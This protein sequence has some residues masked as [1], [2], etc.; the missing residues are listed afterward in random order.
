M[1]CNLIWAN[2]GTMMVSE[3]TTDL[4]YTYHGTAWP[5]Y[6]DINICPE[7]VSWT[8]LVIWARI[9]YGSCILSP[10]WIC[11]PCRVCHPLWAIGLASTATQSHPEILCAGSES[12]NATLL[13]SFHLRKQESLKTPEIEVITVNCID[14]KS[15]LNSS[16]T[17]M[18]KQTTKRQ[19]FEMNVCSAK[20]AKLMKY[21]E[22]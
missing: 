18:R 22:I 3:S 12:A 11:L 19:L 16:Y 2:H 9:Y 15:V 8:H 14:R 7:W 5:R 17:L 4:W 20:I 6:T 21:I 13:W 1:W 10:V